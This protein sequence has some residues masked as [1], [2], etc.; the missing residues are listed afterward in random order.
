MTFQYEK[1]PDKIYE[2]SFSIIRKEAELSSFSNL[3]EKIAVR[4][5]HAL[6]LV[7]LEKHIQFTPGFVSRV[8]DALEKGARIICDTKMVSE[9]ITKARLPAN[10]QIICTLNEKSVPEIAKRIS[11]TRTAAAIHLWEDYIQDSLI[12]FGNAPTALFYLLEFLNKKK[13]LKPAGIIGCPVG[14]VGA[15]ESK[16]ALIEVKTLNSLVVKGR[17]GGSAVAVAAV[18]ALAQEKE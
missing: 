1:N 15:A 16:Q 7:G 5:I 2:Q 9:G 10:N 11:N 18:N 14:F 3:E 8:R 17:L 4:M 6:G 13:D 12:V